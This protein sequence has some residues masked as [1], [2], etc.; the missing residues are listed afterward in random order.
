M[1]EERETDESPSDGAEVISMRLEEGRPPPP[2]KPSKGS[3]S[4]PPKK[5]K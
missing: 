2:K 4:P 1:T 3:A 5:K